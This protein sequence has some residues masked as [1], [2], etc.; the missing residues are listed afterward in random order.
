[1][2]A[3]LSRLNYSPFDMQRMIKFEVEISTN[4][5]GFSIKFSGQCHAPLTLANIIHTPHTHTVAW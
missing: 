4:M 2:V 1:M 5:S 3:L